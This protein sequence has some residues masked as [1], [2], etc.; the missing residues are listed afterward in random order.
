MSREQLY[1][2]LY[3]CQCLKD[4]NGSAVVGVTARAEYHTAPAVS[5]TI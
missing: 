4:L 1:L 2:L 3:Y 5:F